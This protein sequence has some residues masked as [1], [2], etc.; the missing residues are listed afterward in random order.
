MNSLNKI[1]SSTKELPEVHAKRG[2]REDFH[3][4]SH[5]RHFVKSRLP[6]ENNH[7]VI[8]DVSFNLDKSRDWIIRWIKA[9]SKAS[10]ELNIHSE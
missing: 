2:P 1:A 9:H 10:F 4:M 6:I 7:V 5:H 8:V 3:S